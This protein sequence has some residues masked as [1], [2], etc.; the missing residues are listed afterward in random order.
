MEDLLFFHLI[1]L[2]NYH[3]AYGNNLSNFFDWEYSH[4]LSDYLHTY[5]HFAVLKE[6]KLGREKCDE[7][8]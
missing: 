7:R 3:Q 2:E 8:N 4:P 5:N 1:Y 6:N